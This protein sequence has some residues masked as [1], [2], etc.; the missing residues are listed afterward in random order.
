V[1]DVVHINLARLRRQL[2]IPGQTAFLEQ[3]IAALLEH[4]DDTPEIADEILR[5]RNEIW[6]VEA[7][8]W[9]KGY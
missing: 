9:P 3:R 1:G 8:T 5:L 2:P 7:M 4:L 6:L